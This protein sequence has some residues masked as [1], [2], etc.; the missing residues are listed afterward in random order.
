VGP[1]REFDRRLG[2]LAIIDPEGVAHLRGEGGEVGV[3]AAVGQLLLSHPFGAD[4]MVT[5]AR[6]PETAAKLAELPLAEA[7]R[8]TQEALT[9]LQWEAGKPVQTQPMQRARSNAPPPIKPVG[10]SA[11]KSSVE[12]GDA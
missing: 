11:T 5:L 9:I 1:S 7:I 12:L 4:L 8:Q 3:P 10:G 2:Q 6:D